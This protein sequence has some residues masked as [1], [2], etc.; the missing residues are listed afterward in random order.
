MSNRSLEEGKVQ[1]LLVQSDKREATAVLLRCSR[2]LD[3]KSDWNMYDTMYTSRRATY[4]MINNSHT[5]VNNIRQMILL[6][7]SQIAQIIFKGSA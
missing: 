6:Y 4:V 3:S 2:I 5:A 1:R 7:R